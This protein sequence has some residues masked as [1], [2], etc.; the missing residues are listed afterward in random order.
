MFI[1]NAERQNKSVPLRN[2]AREDIADIREWITNFGKMGH[3]FGQH[4]LR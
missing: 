4:L 3:E 2:L 1:K